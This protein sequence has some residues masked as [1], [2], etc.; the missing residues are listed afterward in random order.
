MDYN[1][2]LRIIMSVVGE[3]KNKPLSSSL[4]PPTLHCPTT[5]LIIIKNYNHKIASAICNGTWVN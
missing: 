3:M 5:I 2:L 1:L 4:P